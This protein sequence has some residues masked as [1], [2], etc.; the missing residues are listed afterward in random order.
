MMLSIGP[1]I[2]VK[3]PE[4]QDCQFDY[5]RYVTS[6]SFASKPKKADASIM[7]A[8]RAR[9]DTLF[10]QSCSQHWLIKE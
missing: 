2:G 4:R 8:W 7:L 1:S 9:K 3:M 6:P 5:K 10:R